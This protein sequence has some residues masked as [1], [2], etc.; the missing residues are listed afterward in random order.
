[1]PH[2]TIKNFHLTKNVGGSGE[3]MGCG[4]VSRSF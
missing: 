3:G 4:L 1:M 2:H